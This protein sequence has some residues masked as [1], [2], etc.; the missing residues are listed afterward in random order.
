MRQ[1]NE[2]SLVIVQLARF[3]DIIQT[4]PLLQN[5]KKQDFAISSISVVVDTR[6]AA[7]AS[8]LP[9][10][11]RIIPLDINQ[12]AN[13][14]NGD[15]TQ[16]YW[17][18]RGWIAENIPST[19]FD[20]LILL[21]DDPLAGAVSSLLNAREKSGPVPG[22]SMLRPHRYLHAAL[23]DRALNPL[24]L[25]EVWAA[26]GPRLWPLPT[27]HVYRKNTG[28]TFAHLSTE[29]SLDPWKNKYFAVNIGAGAEVRM[30]RAARL[31]AL[32]HFLLDRGPCFVGFLG[33]E[34]DKTLA[35][36]ILTQLP[37]TVRNRV[38]N[39]VGK[40]SLPELPALLD[41]ADVLISSD[42]GTLQLAAACD[43]KTI[44]LFFGGA[45]PNETDV[46]LR[47]PLR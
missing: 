45:K 3:G 14:L 27:P 34:K 9:E 46:L 12:A 13:L 44:G 31:A 21:N 22:F 18:L 42:T 47:V 1:S 29:S 41:S 17:K 8:L 10:V 15:A 6:S 30:L 4:S 24:H 16:T 5:L 38:F 36:S 28:I 37:E 39:L 43:V 25:S 35:E 23:R 19:T 11:D 26:Y 32:T 20:R 7:A 40:T 33:V 2:K